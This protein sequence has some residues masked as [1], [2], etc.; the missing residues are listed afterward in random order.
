MYYEIEI[1]KVPDPDE[2][3]AKT[4]RRRLKFTSDQIYAFHFTLLYAA[5]QVDSFSHL[6]C[7]EITPIHIRTN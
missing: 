3:V 1:D 4:I 5:A 7:N 6:K 2:Q